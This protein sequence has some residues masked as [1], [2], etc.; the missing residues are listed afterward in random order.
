MASEQDEVGL[1]TIDRVM[2]LPPELKNIITQK[3]VESQTLLDDRV[4][5]EVDTMLNLLYYF[6]DLYKIFTYYYSYP[7]QNIANDLSL[8]DEN[9]ALQIYM[10]TFARPFMKYIPRHI[11]ALIVAKKKSWSRTKLTNDIFAK[12]CVIISIM[13][14]DIQ[15]KCLDETVIELDDLTKRNINQMYV[16]IMRI[17]AEGLRKLFSEPEFEG[18]TLD[19]L[20]WASSKW[21]EAWIQNER[22]DHNENRPHRK[23]MD[24]PL[25][26]YALEIAENDDE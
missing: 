23:L 26:I 6:R 16:K 8:S 21:F 5:E 1:E 19:N 20:V 17:T 25:I 2:R 9:N 24:I 22:E 7:A 11:D 14:H 18:W 12:I 3:L 15:E 13:L 4:K 10:K